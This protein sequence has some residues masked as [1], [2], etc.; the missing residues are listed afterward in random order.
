MKHKNAFDSIKYNRFPRLGIFIF[1]WEL[2]TLSIIMPLI[3]FN[4]ICSKFY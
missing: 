3:L 2:P 1:I 4:Y